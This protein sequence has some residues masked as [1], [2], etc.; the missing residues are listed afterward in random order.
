MLIS[1]EKII[2][3]LRLKLQHE[4]ILWYHH[5]KCGDIVYCCWQ[6]GFC[7]SVA[8]QNIWVN[9][10][11]SVVFSLIYK[12]GELTTPEG[13]L[14][15]SGSESLNCCFVLVRDNQ[16]LCPQLWILHCKWYQLVEGHWNEIDYQAGEWPGALAD[17]TG[18]LLWRK[19]GA[20][21]LRDW[22]WNLYPGKGTRMDSAGLKGQKRA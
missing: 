20:G 22:P 16:K 10:Y 11:T 18:A 12:V 4:F 3:I 13:S 2:T 9:Y 21:G 17:K 14:R 5:N 7:C 19:K 8:H 1:L 6:I 15:T